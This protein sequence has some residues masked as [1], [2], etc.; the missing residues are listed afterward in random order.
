M[1][2]SSVAGAQN[3]SS[4][5][6]IFIVMPWFCLDADTLKSSQLRG[7]CTQPQ[8]K[9]GQKVWRPSRQTFE[10]REPCS[11]LAFKPPSQS[12]FSSSRH[13]HSLSTDISWR[14]MGLLF[15]MDE[16]SNATSLCFCF[17]FPI[18]EENCLAAFLKIKKKTTQHTFKVSLTLA[19]HQHLSI[20]PAG[21]RRKP[22]MNPDTFSQ[23]THVLF[24]FC[25]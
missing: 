17:I 19:V 11:A 6:F 13:Q 2:S 18:K 8:P 9:G 15:S 10:P 16:Q 20:F 22:R 21:S 12:Y 24:L 5:L 25:T 14:F 23:E 1:K 3:S 4:C 7:L